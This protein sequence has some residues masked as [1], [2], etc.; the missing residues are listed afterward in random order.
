MITQDERQKTMKPSSKSDNVIFQTTGFLEPSLKYEVL[1]D[2]PVLASPHHQAY[3][4]QP[5]CT[6][7]SAL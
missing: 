6:Y 1:T 4:H 2:N 7:C 3:Q 5:M